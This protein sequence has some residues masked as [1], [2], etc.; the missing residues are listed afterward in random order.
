MNII[1]VSKKENVGK[2]Y[3][4]CYNGKSNGIWVLK[5]EAENIFELYNEYEDGITNLYYVSE[6]INLEFEE[7]IDW[8]KIPVDAKV[9]VSEDGKEWSKRHFA[10]YVDGKVY[11]FNNGLTSF[12]IDVSIYSSRTTFWKYCKLYQG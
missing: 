5:E 6:I 3:E 8:S 4:A 1:E 11:C 9:L 10:E 2:K 7:V 12:T